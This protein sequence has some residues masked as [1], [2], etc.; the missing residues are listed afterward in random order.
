M[1]RRIKGFAGF[2]DAE[3]DV[4]EFAHHGTDDEFRGLAGS[5]KALSEA[6]SPSGLVQGGHGRHVQGFAQKG[7]ADLGKPR[8]AVNAGPRVML[9]WVGAGKGCRLASIVKALGMGIVGEQDSD[10]PAA[11]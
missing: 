1:T 5:G 9:T 4:Y 11:V 7:M 2:E 10:I 8:F 6:L 3:G